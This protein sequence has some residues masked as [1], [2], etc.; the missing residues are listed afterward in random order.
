VSRRTGFKKG[1][2]GLVPRLNRPTL[3]YC[4][5]V[6]ISAVLTFPYPAALLTQSEER[7]NF[8]FVPF[9]FNSRD[10]L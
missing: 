10:E 8:E 9:N 7:G 2:S 1:A 6:A 5:L 3:S 4:K